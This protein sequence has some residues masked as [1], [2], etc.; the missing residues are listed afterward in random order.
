MNSKQYRYD[1]AM[2]TPVPAAA[3]A[4]DPVAHFVEQLPAAHSAHWVPA[5][6]VAVIIIIQ[7]AFV[8]GYARTTSGRFARMYVHGG[9]QRLAVHLFKGPATALHELSHALMC[10]ATRTPTG[11]IVLWHPKEQPDGSV[12]FGYVQHAP[13]RDWRGALVSLAPGI[14][15]PPAMALYSAALMGHVLPGRR[16]IVH[17]PWWTTAL[18]VIGLV[19]FTTSA[20][21]SAGDFEIMS[22]RH[23]ASV[24]FVFAALIFACVSL[25]GWVYLES[26]LARLVQLLIPVTAV[27]LIYYGVSAR[28]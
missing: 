8:R 23:W 17:T 25:G 24:I 26:I 19:I 1:Q 7:Y 11:K 27:S 13:Y 6:Y 14:L 15:M 21:P 20:F 9:W 12:I 22:W 18:W 3:P 28:T 10:K 2:A 5:L 4:V 16:A